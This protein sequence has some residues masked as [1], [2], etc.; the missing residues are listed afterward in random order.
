MK[1]AQNLYEFWVVTSWHII[2]NGLEMTPYD[3]QAALVLL[4]L[5]FRFLYDTPAVYPEWERL[6][7]PEWERLVTQHAFSGKTAHDAR[8]VAA[9]TGHHFT[10]LL[11]FNTA[12]FARFSEIMVADPYWGSQPHL[13]PPDTTQYLKSQIV[14]PSL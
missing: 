4:L 1:G 8:L 11:T 7:T 3:A 10:L 5:L 6:V 12:V 9:M 13:A 14:T 2:A